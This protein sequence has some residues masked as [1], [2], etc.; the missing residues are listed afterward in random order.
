LYHPFI[1]NSL[2]YFPNAPITDVFEVHIEEERD[3]TSHC[4]FSNPH[5]ADHLQAYGSGFLEGA[6]MNVQISQAYSTFLNSTP[7]VK[8]PTDKFRTFVTNNDNWVRKNAANP[9]ENVQYWQQVNLVLQQFDGVVDGYNT[10]AKMKISKFDFLVFQL[11]WEIGDILTAINVSNTFSKSLKTDY[12]PSIEDAHCSVLVRPTP[13]GTHLFSSH[14]TWTKYAEMLRVYKFY[15][16]AFHAKSTKAP[17]SVFSSFPGVLTSGDDYFVTSQNLV[18]METTNS[19]FNRSLFKFVTEHTVMYWIRVVVA[20]R[21]ADS[22]KEWTHYFS[23]YNSGTYSNQWI[24]VDNK[25]FTKHQPIKPNTLWIAEQIPGYVI[26]ADKS[27]FLQK[28]QHWPSYNVPYFE[29]VYNISGYPAMFQKY[30][31]KFSYSQCPRAQIFARDFSGVTDMNSMKRIMRFNKFQTDPLSLDNACNSISARCDLNDP[32]AK[33]N[34]YGAFGAIDAK[35]TSNALSS[36]MLSEIVC[37][38]TH[39]SQPIFEWNSQWSNVAHFGQP[40][41][42]AFNFTKM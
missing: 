4:V 12:E 6:L 30:G 34:F 10:Y 23:L 22:G 3:A 8:N 2:T 14:V 28:Y 41:F 33:G 15:N 9:T 36:S 37:G 11:K 17:K 27:D 24:V 40:Q 20:N 26:S 39:D 19:V 1:C 5:V 29:F 16:T 13:D 35:I 42:F 21:M 38:P 32:H 25:L 7:F 18:V 31:N